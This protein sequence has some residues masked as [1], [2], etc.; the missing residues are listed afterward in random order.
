MKSYD[1][2]IV[3]SGMTAASAALAIREVDKKAVI[4][5][6]GSENHAPYNRP[7]LSKKL[8][9][10]KPED[11]IWFKLPEDNFDLVTN[12]RVESLDPEHKQIVDE[13]GNRYGYKKLLLA[14]GGTPRVIPN[15]P[16][17]IIY[18]RTV[19]D[20]HMLRSWL[21]KQ[22]K[23]VILGGGFIGSEVAASL[24][25]NGEK[26]GMIYL[27]GL[28]GER[29]YPKGLAEYVTRYFQGKGIEV[30][31]SVDIQGIEKKGNSLV[32]HARDGQ[33]ITADHIIAGLGI[34]PN[35]ELAAAA[36][37][38]IAGP[39]GGRGIIVDEHL[40]TNFENIYAA[41]D[42]ASFYNP[43]LKRSMRVEHEDNAL[44]MGKTAGL[45]MAGQVTPYIHQPYF[46]SD[47]FE[48]GYEA[49]GEL[50]SRLDII[51]D[52]VDPYKQGIV[53]YLRDQKVRGVLLW[54]TWGQ[55]DA[56]R[57]LIAEGETHTEADL[58]VRLPER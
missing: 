1:Y 31:P 13:H 43:A 58:K 4:G 24:V 18:Y 48:L 35:T 22:A 14:T 45:N 23:I 11:T 9:H 30:H 15:A 38:A 21:G 6:I 19:D 51:E 47:I 28:I 54:N 33:D 49:V 5:M 8:W 56:A 57:K 27:E 16:S 20:Y 34:I 29:V 52:W 41:G 10:G 46:Y 2:L 3:G 39:E 12:T 36:G 44:T 32:M 7:P 55:V 26:V 53:Y 37:I 40:R 42:V 50:D 17:E 25:D